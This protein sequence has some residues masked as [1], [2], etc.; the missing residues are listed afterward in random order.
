MQEAVEYSA[1]ELHCLFC[2]VGG[3]SCKIVS[4]S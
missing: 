1:L 3:T 4:R 2:G